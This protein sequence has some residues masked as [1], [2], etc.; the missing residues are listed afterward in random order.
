[1]RAGQDILATSSREKVQ[2]PPDERRRINRRW[3]ASRTIFTIPV[4][5]ASLTFPQ[6]SH[7]VIGTLPAGR[8]TPLSIASWGSVFIERT[9]FD[10]GASLASVFNR[11]GFYWIT[12]LRLMLPCWPAVREACGN[13][14]S[15][16]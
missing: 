2:P 10:T 9:C 8:L 5:L 15:E 12:P 7:C 6:R 13:W 16:L 4:C 11:E 3:P 14:R 1:M